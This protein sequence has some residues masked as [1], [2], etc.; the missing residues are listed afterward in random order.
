MK[1]RDMTE[2]PTSIASNVYA[3]IDAIDEAGLDG[4]AIIKALIGD[5]LP[6]NDPTERI[7]ESTFR[8]LYIAAEQVTGDSAIGLRIG[9]Y[10][11][12]RSMHALGNSLTSSSTLREF[13]TRL[14][15][16]LRLITNAGHVEIVEAGPMVKLQ[17]HI[18]GEQ[19]NYHGEDA[20][21]SSLVLTIRDISSQQFSPSR[22][23]TRRPAEGVDPAPY[24]D[25][26]DCEVVFACD[27]PAI[28][29]K[30]ALFDKPLPSASKEIAFHNDQII[31]SYIAKLDKGDI[32]SRAKTAIIE[33]M[34]RDELSKENISS[35]LQ[36][37]SRS[38]HYQ[39]SKHGLSFRELV[40]QVR[41]AL[42]LRY[43][44][45]GDVSVTEISYLLAFSDTSSFTRAFKRWTGVAP[46]KYRSHQ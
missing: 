38:L 15:E 29:F 32:V 1:T 25:I 33:S 2:Y 19:D 28:Y 39:L 27:A 35:K 31:L 11:R 13:A 43:L 12:Q 3:V 18:M 45:S 14:V 26:F 34:G 7:P 36:L 41:R 16:Y 40:E 22:V 4:T 17:I 46:S 9:K 30:R 5:E 21:L 42:A 44:E 20:F 6:R 23:E 37:S 10:V 24:E 8:D